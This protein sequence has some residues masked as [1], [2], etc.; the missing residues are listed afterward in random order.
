MKKAISVILAFALAFG[1]LLPA[2][3]AT[4]ADAKLQFNDDGKFRIMQISDIQGI[5]AFW[6]L[7][8]RQEKHPDPEWQKKMIALVDHMDEALCFEEIECCEYYQGQLLCNTCNGSIF[9]LE[10]NLVP[11]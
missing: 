11:I 9:V 8:Q 5:C 7:Q 3:A 2:S 1:M 4:E 10:D 6:R